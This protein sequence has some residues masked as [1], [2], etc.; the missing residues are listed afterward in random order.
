MLVQSY[1][2]FY[3]VSVITYNIIGVII[4][5]KILKR[6][7]KFTTDCIAQWLHHHSLW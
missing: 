7:I 3:F 4:S 2:Y 1:F 6:I 5:I